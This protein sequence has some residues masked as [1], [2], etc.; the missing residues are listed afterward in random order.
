MSN[1]ELMTN[2]GNPLYHRIVTSFSRFND[3]AIQRF[4]AAKPFAIR[5]SCFVIL[6][7]LGV[8]PLFAQKRPITEKDLWDFVWIADPQVSPDGDRVAFVRVTVNEKKEGYDTSIW[9]SEE[10]RVGKECRSWVVSE[11]LK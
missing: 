3:S 11:Y 4:N 1:D 8:A 7:A 6:L 5:Y 2:H 10:R 9:R